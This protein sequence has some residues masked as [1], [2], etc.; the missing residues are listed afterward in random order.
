MEMSHE[1]GKQFQLL[2]FEIQAC[3]VR[4]ILSDFSRRNQTL[5]IWGTKSQWCS[6][7]K[8]ARDTSQRTLR[9]ETFP[10]GTWLSYSVGIWL[11]KCQ[12]LFQRWNNVDITFIADFF[13][14][15]VNKNTYKSMLIFL[16]DLY[17]ES[18]QCLQEH[19]KEISAL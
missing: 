19:T 6:T 5:L 7:G 15:K 16:W 10:A 9:Y 12:L 3:T 13:E 11:K 1:R 17:V 18:M 2:W 14:K 4:I 8:L